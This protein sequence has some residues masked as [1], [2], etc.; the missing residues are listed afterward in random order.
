M[1]RRWAVAGCLLLLC[2]CHVSQTQVDAEIDGRVK[3]EMNVLNNEVIQGISTKD[4]VRIEKI[5]SDSLWIKGGKS[6][7]RQILDNT[8]RSEEVP[9]YLTLRSSL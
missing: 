3:T 4:P 2:S 8:H 9:F 7:S 1:N 6:I 5:C